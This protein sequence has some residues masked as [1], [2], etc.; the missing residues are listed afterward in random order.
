MSEVSL[1]QLRCFVAVYAERSFTRAARTLDM[2]QPPVSQAIATLES[3]LGATLFE[4][5]AREVVPTAVAHAL[6]PEAVELR[7][8]AESLPHLVAAARDGRP[9]RRLRVGAVS[10]AF[11]TLI[12]AL[13]PAL[14]DFSLDVTD[15][16]SARLVHALKQGDLDVALVRDLVADGADQRIA[17][18]EPLV[19]AVPGGHRLAAAADVEIADIADEPLVLFERD[20]APVAFDLTVAAFLHAG[21]TLRIGSRVGSEQAILGLVGAG[22]GIALVP[23]SQSLHPWPGVTFLRLRGA[24]ATY[25]L[26]VHVAPGD[27]LG[28]LTPA[29]ATLARW[30]SDHLTD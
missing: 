30:A 10:S 17:F 23:R 18:R 24:Q 3:H 13:V 19:V 26:S 27:P 16:G 11:P 29:T 25:P 28:V 1:K 8:R 5:R 4:R 15:G 20:R 7:R 14:T 6:Y 12:A 9:P 21:R 2:A 22:Q